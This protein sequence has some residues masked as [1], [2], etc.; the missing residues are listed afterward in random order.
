MPEAPDCP[1]AQE[2]VIRGGFVIG[3]R[4]RIDSARSG[5]TSMCAVMRQKDFDQRAPVS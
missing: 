1:R 2:R 4:F 3:R 5:A